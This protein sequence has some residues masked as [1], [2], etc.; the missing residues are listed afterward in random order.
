M[1]T[2]VATS[3]VEL[4]LVV[5]RVP[6]REVVELLQD[7]L[8]VVDRGVGDEAAAVQQVDELAPAPLDP[9]AL[10]VELELGH[11]LGD[12]LEQPEVEEGHAAVVEQH[13]VAGVRVAAEL[14]VAVHAA[15]VEAED[16]LADPVAL[17]LAELLHLLEA[18][19]GDELA[20]DHALV[21]RA[22]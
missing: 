14:V 3:G 12:P 15:E 18:A 11:R 19:A 5:A 17:V 7:P 4:D 8:L 16:D 10:R 2:S 22:R 13:A 1:I 20:D 21:A 9:Q 6:P